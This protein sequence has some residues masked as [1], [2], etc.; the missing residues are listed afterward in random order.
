MPL[1]DVRFVDFNLKEFGST[2]EVSIITKESYSKWGDARIIEE[3]KT[4][5]AVVNVLTEA[6]KEVIEGISKS[7]DLVFY[8]S[9][10][11]ENF[12]KR[13]NVIIYKGE[14]YEISDVVHFSIN[15]VTYLIQARTKKV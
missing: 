10:K 2:I 14:T 9:P 6:D 11:D 15:D 3:K 8:F 7:G 12:V 4:T 5:K 1:L 13:G